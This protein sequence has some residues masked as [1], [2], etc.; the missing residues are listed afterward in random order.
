MAMAAT[1]AASRPGLSQDDTAVERTI[2]LVTKM[3][4]EEDKDKGGDDDG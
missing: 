4:S 1:T 2:I 3:L